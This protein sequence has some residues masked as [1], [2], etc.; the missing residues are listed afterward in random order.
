V[1]KSN[2]CETPGIALLGEMTALL[3][4]L[5]VSPHTLAAARLS[6][7]IDALAEDLLPTPA[8]SKESQPER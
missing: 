3:S 8:L 7:A 5:D 6:S 1:E 4:R 2:F